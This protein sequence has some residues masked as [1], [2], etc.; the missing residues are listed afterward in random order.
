MDE[1]R[2]D[3][4]ITKSKSLTTLMSVWTRTSWCLEKG[5]R[6]KNKNKDQLV[7]CEAVHG[8][9]IEGEIEAWWKR[10]L[11]YF[12]IDFSKMMG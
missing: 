10:D 4:K 12:F 11:L 5:A 2:I 8:S 3:E 9:K 1:K 7:L 6:W